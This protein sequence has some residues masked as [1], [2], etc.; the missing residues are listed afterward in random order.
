V[1][2]VE[3][4]DGEAIVGRSRVGLESLDVAAVFPHNPWARS[5]RFK[6]SASVTGMMP[7]SFQVTAVL[8]D[9]TRLSV[10]TV[11]VQRTWDD[12]L[13]AIGAPLVSVVIP[14][15]D[16]SRF[17]GDAIRSVLAQSYPHF[18]IVIV[19]DGSHDNAAA[20][21]RRYCGVRYVRQANR[22]LSAAR[23]T[24]LGHSRG[25]YLVFLDA[26]DRLRPD[27]LLTGLA[28]FVADPTAAFVSGQCVHIAFD[29][30]PLPSE[31]ARVVETDHYR[32]LLRDCFIWTSGAV[33]F[34]RIV[35]TCVGDYDPLFSEASDHDLFLRVARAYRVRCHPH[36]VAEYRRH[37]TNMTR[38]PGAN[39]RD[40]ID[41]L[42]RHRRTCPGNSRPDWEAYR[43]GLAFA[44]GYFGEPLVAD[45]V[46]AAATGEWLRALNGYRTLITHYPRGAARVLR[47]LIRQWRADH[48]PGTRRPQPLI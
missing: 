11:R 3:L 27:A 19:D 41:V 36:V 46:S 1:A 18:E 9:Q 10:A 28:E 2:A 5:A 15:F 43:A 8:S 16:S 48:L 39:L 33:M 35:F 20:V 44:R 40:R 14:C 13:S 37:G 32:E 22:G 42:R 4:I 38:D 17:L 30:T 29:G 24:G 45:V 31:T 12:A 6:I 26:D 47:W 7:L 25:S 34:R 21:A 23:N